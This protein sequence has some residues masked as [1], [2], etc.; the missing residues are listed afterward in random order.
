LNYDSPGGWASDSRCALAS[1]D[2]DDLFSRSGRTRY[3]YTD[4]ADESWVMF[5]EALEPF[6]DEMKLYQKRAMPD[7][8]KAYCAGII[9]G[10]WEFERGSYS[11]FADWVVDAPGE[12]I[13]NVFDEWKKGKPN[14][15]DIEEIGQIIAEIDQERRR[16]W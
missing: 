12:N 3:G 8:A 1:L 6:I 15:S 10:I 13:D 2:V 16:A 9:K 4:P 7:I 11:D 14:E 5:E